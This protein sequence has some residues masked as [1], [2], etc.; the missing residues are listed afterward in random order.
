M[1]ATINLDS[2]VVVKFEGEDK[3]FSV[4][5]LINMVEFYNPKKFYYEDDVPKDFTGICKIEYDDA[6]V[7]F[8]DGKI[9]RDDGPAYI[10]HG[11]FEGCYG[12]FYK[13]KL[14]D[15]HDCFDVESWKEFIKELNMS[16]S[17]KCA[18]MLANKANL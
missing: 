7:Y 17:E 2:K 1:N 12:W 3:I 4:Q 13:G 9:H 18:H 8:K 11:S 6:T 10:C 16:Y 5:E 14:I 15:Y